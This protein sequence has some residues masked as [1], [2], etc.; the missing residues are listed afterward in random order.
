MQS[1]PTAKQQWIAYSSPAWKEAYGGR[2]LQMART[3]AEQRCGQVLWVLQPGFEQRNAMAC[4]RELINEVQ[5]EAVRLDRTR[6]LEI[7]TNEAAYMKDK[8]HF[9]RAYLLQLGPAMFQLVDTA[10]QIAHGQCLV[11]HRNVSVSPSD[12]EMLPLHWS[13][14]DSTEGI[15]VPDHTGVQCRIAVER[16]T[17]LRKAVHHRPSKGRRHKA[18]S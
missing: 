5:R 18:R 2:T 11:C 7:V 13:R 17:R 15:W 10:R 1:M 4:H 9:N 16:R 3:L 12:A 8:T 14:T 6:V